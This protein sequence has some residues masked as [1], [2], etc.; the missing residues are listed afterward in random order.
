MYRYYIKDASDLGWFSFGWE[1]TK[2]KLIIKPALLKSYLCS[3]LSCKVKGFKTLNGCSELATYSK[4]RHSVKR[5]CMMRCI[6]QRT[7]W[8]YII[9]Y[10]QRCT[11]RNKNIV[12]WMLSIP[13]TCRLSAPSNDATKPSKIACKITESQVSALQACEH[14]L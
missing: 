5:S 12:E 7:C 11:G 10:Q 3:L 14:R 8:G 4:T 9:K 6:K 2:G 1:I 13:R